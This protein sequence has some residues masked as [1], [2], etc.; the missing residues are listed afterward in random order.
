MRGQE[1]QLW[2]PGQSFASEPRKFTFDHCF[3]SH[4]GCL[5]LDDG[6]C[7]P[8][9]EHEHGALYAD[10]ER[11]YK[12]LGREVVRSA[13]KGYNAAL[14]AY[15]QSGSGKS[16]SMVGYGANT[17]MV[18]RLCED[19]F[20]ELEKKRSVGKHMEFEVELSM[21]EIYN[22]TVFDLLVASKGQRKGLKVREHPKKGFFAEGLTKC[23]VTNFRDVLSRIEEGTTNR[24]IAATNTNATSSR[25]HTLV[26]LTLMQRTKRPP[27]PE[28]TKTSIV[29]LVDLA[30]SER[31]SA[32]KTS[33]DRLREGIAINQSLSCLGNCVHAL[34]EKAKGTNVKVPYRESTLTRLLMTALGGNSKTIMLATISPSDVNYEETLSTLRYAERT[35]EIKNLVRVNED[36]TDKLIRELR[37]ENEALKKKLT[38]GNVDNVLSAGLTDEE[39]NQMKRKWEEDMQ[40]IIKE[41]E[42]QMLIMKQ[43][44][45]EKLKGSA[46][47]EDTDKLITEEEKKALPHLSNLN[48]DPLLSGRI[49]HILQKGKSTVGKAD[50]DI[51]MLGVGIQD[52]H[53]IIQRRDTEVTVEKGCP[54]AK[55]LV[56]G[57][58]VTSPVTLRHNDRIVFGQTQLFLFVNPRQHDRH[59]LTKFPDVTY[60]MAQEEIALRAGIK[61]QDDDSIETALLNR[62]MI[63]VLPKIDEANAMSAELDRGVH[64]DILLVSPQLLGRQLGRTEVYVK[65]RYL[66]AEHEF[67]WTKEKFLSRVFAMKEMYSKYENGEEWEV[68]EERDPFLEDPNTE[69]RIGTV[70]V[71]LQPLAYMVDLRE[72]LEILNFKGEEVG[73]LNVEMKPCSESGREYTEKDI[74]FLDSPGELVGR[75]LNFVVRI[76]NC[77]SLPKRF[78]DV[79]CKYRMFKDEEDTATEAVS[80]TSD[81]DFNHTK[82]FSYRPATVELVEYLSDSYVAISVWGIQVTPIPAEG[83]RPKGRALKKNFQENLINQTNALMNGF[84]INGRNVDPNK[85]SIIVELLLMKK[86]QARQNQKLENLRRLV[87]S[88]ES[89]HQRRVPVSVVK[90][91]LLV[92]S[93]EAAEQLLSKLEGRQ[94]TL[95]TDHQSLLGLLRPDRQTPTMAAA[96]IQWWALFLG[97]YQYKLQYVHGKQLLTADALS[98]LPVEATGLALDGDPPDTARVELALRRPWALPVQ[99]FMNAAY[100]GAQ[101]PVP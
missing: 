54:E 34:A 9:P 19:L 6:Y 55:V 73:I 95:V 33:G 10:Q 22:E 96:R 28:T 27:G 39:L 71:Y 89:Q 81:P 63:E 64:F 69:V 88:A 31:Q 85:Q 65:A 43:S 4:D 42:A 78:T 29:H 62:D 99:T 52:K 77:R 26:T 70:Q 23:L 60:E 38:K 90:D 37:Q 15:G 45:E 7:A 48:L 3:W 46:R 57:S 11:V 87:E 82:T 35:K 36:P 5:R 75:D 53:A 20:Q 2:S 44:Y 16:Y 86:Q 59:D 8:D 76:L 79:R 74:V 91:L 40:A 24:S 93:A 68:D 18:P 49:V 92:S 30:G 61:L 58:P 50:A 67:D 97:G 98:R 80:G 13:W 47:K 41:N 51:I 32:A 56:N 101:C 12:D 1:T 83:I 66:K 72:Q 14:L 84:R 94:F 100:S 21:M 25:A 17:G